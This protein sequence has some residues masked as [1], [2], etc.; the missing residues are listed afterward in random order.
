[1]AIGTGVATA[2]VLALLSIAWGSTLI[3]LRDVVA[4]LAYATGLGG[5]APS[6]PVG[7]IVVDLRLPR[8]LLAICVGTGLGVVGALLQTV[9]RNDLADPFLFGLSS[10][11]AGAVS[12]ITVFGDH[13]GT[14][15]L[16]IAAFTGGML[17]AIIVLLLVSRI[18]GQGPERL[19]LAGLA[20]SF[21]FTALTNYLVFSGDQRA[22]HSVLFWT[23]GGL[24]LARWDN[25]GLASLGAAGVVVF[26]LGNHR[27]LDAFLAGENTAE[28][29]GVQVARFRML[30]FVVA[31]FASAILVAVAGVIG[32]VG[33]MIPHLARRVAGQLHLR[34]VV[35]CAVF[36]AVLLLASD[37]FAR[38]LLPPQELPIGIVTSSIGAFFVV[39][40]LINNR[41]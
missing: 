34:L 31:A 5:E 36:G 27:K 8:T 6:G 12:V 7:K 30:T 38:T 9:T 15:T 4:S 29:L 25:I 3:P 14:W 41:L 22:A 26:A 11:A 18:H 19:I 32:F 35:A 37:L 10:G 40:M 20:V 28:S 13:F 1:M 17:A 23:M 24:G 16:P 21:L 39:S 2:I 33:L